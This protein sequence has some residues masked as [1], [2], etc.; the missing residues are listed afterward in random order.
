MI[1][2]NNV[3]LFGLILVVSTLMAA[4]FGIGYIGPKNLW[5][6]DDDDNKP[7]D[8]TIKFDGNRYVRPDRK[9]Q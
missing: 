9:A 7:S 6:Y 8:N 5:G 3:D 1:M 2:L 4:S